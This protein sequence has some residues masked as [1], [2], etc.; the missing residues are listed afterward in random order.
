MTLQQI[1]LL[2]SRASLPYPTLLPSY[3]RHVVNWVILGWFS[4]V[5]GYLVYISG[6]IQDN[7]TSNILPFSDTNLNGDWLQRWITIDL[8]NINYELIS[9]SHSDLLNKKGIVFNEE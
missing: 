2:Y 9:T 3:F 6:S 7:S 5:V 4:S 8:S 1:P